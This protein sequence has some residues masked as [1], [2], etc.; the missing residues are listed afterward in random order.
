MH[1][2]WPTLTCRWGMRDCVCVYIMPEF[3]HTSFCVFTFLC[4]PFSGRGIQI[5]VSVHRVWLWMLDGVDAQRVVCVCVFTVESLND[6]HTKRATRV[7][8]RR[9]SV[10]ASHKIESNFVGCLDKR[11][12][13]VCV[14]GARQRTRTQ[15][16]SATRNTH[17]PLWVFE[18]ILCWQ[19]FCLGYNS[20]FCSNFWT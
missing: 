9:G 12:K 15:H 2:R 11:L 13:Y 17:I 10:C 6:K 8:V 5:S 4:V 20:I 16:T 7:R 19:N 3:K 18:L 1:I 14:R